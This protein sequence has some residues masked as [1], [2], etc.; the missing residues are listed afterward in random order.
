MT[1][2]T[3]AKHILLWLPLAIVGMA[4]GM[5]CLMSRLTALPVFPKFLERSLFE[6]FLDPWHW[7]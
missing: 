2:P 6:H 7:P 4:L 1:P 3:T 5:A